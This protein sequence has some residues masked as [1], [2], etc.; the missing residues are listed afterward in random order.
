M[1]E[2]DPD[3]PAI[4]YRSRADWPRDRAAAEME[5]IARGSLAAMIRLVMTDPDEDYWPYRIAADVAV[6]DGNAIIV[7]DRQLRGGKRRSR[8]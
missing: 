8:R 2:L 3:M 1:P 4:L 6:I 7:L 5:E